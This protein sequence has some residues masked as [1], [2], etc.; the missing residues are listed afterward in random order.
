MGPEIINFERKR[1]T[2][3][4]PGDFLGSGGIL[5]HQRV[6]PGGCGSNMFDLGRFSYESLT[7]L[8]PRFLPLG[9]FFSF[10]GS[11]PNK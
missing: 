9:L 3:G 11:G 8:A 6:S 7:P 1:L 2:N 5:E 10:L 4:V